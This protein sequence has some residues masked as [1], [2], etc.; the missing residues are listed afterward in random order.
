MYCSI[1]RVFTMCFETLLCKMPHCCLLRAQESF[2]LIL[3]SLNISSVSPSSGFSGKQKMTLN[4]THT[5]GRRLVVNSNLMFVIAYATCLY[6]PTTFIRCCQT[7]FPSLY[8]P[9]AFRWISQNLLI[10]PWK[11]KEIG[12]DVL[13]D[14]HDFV[15]GN[16]PALVIR[17]QRCWLS[18]W[19]LMSSCG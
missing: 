1:R 13:Q 16:R 19:A 14:F 3:F 17:W 12:N 7:E 2:T 15:L 10:T 9:Q 5:P 4:K 8:L 18:R 11:K 6:L